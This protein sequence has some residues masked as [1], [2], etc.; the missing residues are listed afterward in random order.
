MTERTDN[1]DAEE[2]SREEFAAH[3][4]DHDPLSGPTAVTF[5]SRDEDVEKGSTSAVSTPPAEDVTRR[6]PS[7]IEAQEDLKAF[8]KMH[9]VGPCHLTVPAQSAN[10]SLILTWI[11][12]CTEK[13]GILPQE[14]E[15][16]MKKS[17]LTWN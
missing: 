6:K 3:N 9:M 15:M 5:A 2:P 17:V 13:L 8:A 10:I 7:A 12:I 1:I 11:K 16:S 14:R 4:T